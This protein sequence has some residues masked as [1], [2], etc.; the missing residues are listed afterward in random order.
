MDKTKLKLLVRQL[1]IV[2]DNIKA[3]VLSDAESYMSMDT[4]EEIKKTE[5]HLTYDE[6]LDDDDGY[7]D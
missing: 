7:P 3:E 6:I 4:Y 5:P 2:V 1:E